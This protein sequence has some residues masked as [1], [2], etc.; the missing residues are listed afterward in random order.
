MR[1]KN[2]KT[3]NCATE[4]ERSDFTV[5]IFHLLKKKILISFPVCSQVY[6]MFP[7]W[8][9]HYPYQVAEYDECPGFDGWSV[10]QPLIEPVPEERWNNRLA[11]WKPWISEKTDLFSFFQV[12]V[13]THFVLIETMVVGGGKESP[14]WQKHVGSGGHWQGQNLERNSWWARSLSWFLC[15]KKFPTCEAIYLSSL[16]GLQ[17]L[18]SMGSVQKENTHTHTH[19]KKGVQK[20]ESTQRIGDQ[21]SPI[22]KDFAFF[23]S[24]KFWDAL[25][26]VWPL[27]LWG[28]EAGLVQSFCSL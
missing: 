9:N 5:S 17:T 21:K 10:P 14:Y 25:A 23:L 12:D 7:V 1:T 18:T 22:M 15:L 19:T 3:V 2:T 28:P 4:S 16:W 26:H 13:L 8:Y 24:A 27:V 11:M 6:R 20:K